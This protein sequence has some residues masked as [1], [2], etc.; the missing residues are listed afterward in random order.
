MRGGVGGWWVG[1][2]VAGRPTKTWGFGVF[3]E[4]RFLENLKFFFLQK[5]MSKTTQMKNEKEEN[6]KKKTEKK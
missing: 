5:F 1:R 6:E 4:F 2:W 3:S